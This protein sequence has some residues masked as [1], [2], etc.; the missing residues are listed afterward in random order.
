MTATGLTVPLRDTLTRFG[1]KWILLQRGTDNGDPAD[2]DV[3]ARVEA[4]AL[5]ATISLSPGELG[6]LVDAAR[7][8]ADQQQDNNQN[9][10]QWARDQDESVAP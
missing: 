7:D 3:A 6:E 2:P 1:A 4:V 10:L 5:I 9:W 8:L